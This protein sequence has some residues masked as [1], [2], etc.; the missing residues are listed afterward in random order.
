MKKHFAPS[1]NVKTEAKD[2]ADQ[3]AWEVLRTPDR[4]QSLSRV[5]DIVSNPLPLKKMAM[6]VLDVPVGNWF[7]PWAR[8]ELS[9]IQYRAYITAGQG[10]RN[11]DFMST[12]LR[13]AEICRSMGEPIPYNPRY[14]VRGKGVD[15]YTMTIRRL[16]DRISNSKRSPRR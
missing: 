14:L 6:R 4:E 3:S 11:G 12:I 16:L 5:G 13:L 7:R 10:I 8:K 1:L 2:E 15:Y 9:D